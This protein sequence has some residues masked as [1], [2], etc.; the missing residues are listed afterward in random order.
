MRVFMFSY[1]KCEGEIGGA[2]GVNYKLFL[3]NQK[4]KL[5]PK[6]YHLFEDVTLISNDNRKY[7]AFSP[8]RG[9]T[10]LR[11]KRYLGKI[12]LWDVAAHQKRLMHIKKW[13]KSINDQYQ[14]RDDD[15]YIFHDFES[16]YVFTNLFKGMKKISL[17]YHQEGSLYTEWSSV[18]GFKS[19][20]YQK[21]LNY[22]QRK[23]LKVLP[24]MA[25]PSK[26]AENALRQA[27]DL[28]IYLNSDID[29]LYNGV[30]KPEKLQISDNAVNVISHIKNDIVFITISRLNYSKGVERIP[31]FLGRLKR[32][33]YKFKW[34][35]IGTGTM[36]QKLFEEITTNGIEEDTIWIKDFI[37][38]D[39]ILGLFEVSHFYIMF[40]RWSIFD[41]ATIEAMAYGVVP[42]LSAVGGNLEVVENHVNGVLLDDVE[43]CRSVEEVMNFQMYEKIRSECIKTQREKFSDKAFIEQYRDY[44]E[45]LKKQNYSRGGV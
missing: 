7:R 23:G 16:A 11:L 37:N 39:D 32:S 17:V 27:D 31:A 38:H 13:L 22:L 35:V 1:R 20:V 10:D 18:C 14:F 34:I 25:F 44:I 24:N 15:V 43:D 28:M 9:K 6:M 40:H 2:S 42:I 45:K 4:Y 21:Y 5:I 12:G 30:R 41:F 33:G 8:L 36:Q 19:Y 26:G 29:I 3:A